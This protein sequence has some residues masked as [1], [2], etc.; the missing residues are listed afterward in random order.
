MGTAKT[1]KDKTQAREKARRVKQIAKG[2]LTKA[3]G[4]VE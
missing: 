3:N 1:Y 2:T 4:L